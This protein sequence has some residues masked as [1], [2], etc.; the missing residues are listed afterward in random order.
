M[1][2]KSDAE[3]ARTRRRLLAA[4]LDILSNEGA[5]A[6]TTTRVA[7]AAGIVQSGFYRH[8]ANMDACLRE[9]LDP[10]QKHVRQ[11]IAQRRRS[12]FARFGADGADGPAHYADS[13]AF[14]DAHPQLSEI[15]IKRRFDDGAVGTLMREFHEGLVADLVDDLVM[16][17]RLLGRERDRT[18]CDTVARLLLGAV[19]S[20][21][22]SRLRG[23]AGKEELGAVLNT[24]ADAASEYIDSPS[25]PG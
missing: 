20:A 16:L 9:A 15:A 24:M 17:G 19:F 11:D 7:E 4:T 14:V 8:F 1:A 10:I 5:A 6:L 3:T 18:R 23:E 13:L 22:E 25:R 12:W 2:R 21:V